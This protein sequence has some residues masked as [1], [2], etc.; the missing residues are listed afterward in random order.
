MKIKTSTI[1]GLTIATSVACALIFARPTAPRISPGSI[2]ATDDMTVARFDHTATLLANGQVLIL[3]GLERNGVMQPT[4]ELFDPATGRFTPVGKP[5]TPR[6]W[7]ATSVRLKDGKVLIAG[8]STATCVS[9]SLAAAELYDPV[10]R[11]FSM[12]SGMSNARAG[13]ISILLPNGDALVFGGTTDVDGGIPSA[14]VYHPGTGTFSAAGAMHIIGLSQAVLL[15]DGRVLLVGA[16]GAEL[17]DPVTNRFTTTGKM[18]VPRT[19]FG[20]AL[21]P[22]GRVLIAGGQTGG[23]W[24]PKVTSTQIYDPSSGMFTA[25]PELNIKRFKLAKG[26]VTLK[27]GRVLIAGGADQPEIYDPTSGAFTPIPG[28]RLDG[29]CFSTA[30][31]LS[32][33]QVLLAGGYRVSGGPGV[34][35]AWLYKP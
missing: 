20:A 21:L 9:C 25:G 2:V 12:T 13:A 3:G 6:G 23:A 15:K 32:N 28:N 33:G 31:L 30:T 22:D 16:S 8:G 4:A 17:Y 34:S 29:F 5:Q 11:T 18:T 26:V 10:T 14:E 24:G 19:K 7:G 35:H 27:D 1:A